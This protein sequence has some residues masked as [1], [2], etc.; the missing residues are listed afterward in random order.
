MLCGGLAGGFQPAH[1]DA[2]P[3]SCCI[4]LVDK[5][6]R[7]G[8]AAVWSKR[9]LGRLESVSRS[10]AAASPPPGDQP[11]G[12]GQHTQSSEPWTSGS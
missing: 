7:R 6:M 8:E 12:H 11:R 10:S 4:P 9:G 2:P 1:P 5:G 3:H